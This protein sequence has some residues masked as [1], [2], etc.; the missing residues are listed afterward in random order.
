MTI[1]GD[2]QNY[3]KNTAPG[4]TRNW[5]G[6]I[7]T[8][9]DNKQATYT[10]PYNNQLSLNANTPLSTLYQN[11][12]IAN[13]WDTHYGTDITQGLAP[14]QRQEFT[15]PT[16]LYPTSTSKQSNYSSGHSHSGINWNSPLSKGLLPS[17][18]STGQ[19][20]QSLTEN[21]GQTLQDQY[22]NLMQRALQPQAFQG[23]LND[24]AS[25]RMLNS[26]VAKDALSSAGKGIARMVADQA[27]NS[28]LAQQQA[29]MQVPQTLAN[30]ISLSQETNQSN[31][32]SS[33]SS[34]R[35]SNP[36]EPY[37]LMSQMLRYQ[38][39]V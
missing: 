15:I 20:L 4:T 25:K 17:L 2:Y 19:N 11:P 18:L 14:P 26:T 27:F 10:D 31:K 35:S 21:M 29:Q 23:T 34:A 36:L 3:F 1:L 5:A 39:S 6:G 24:L 12:N 32:S 38:P 16:D 37:E 22:A 13:A 8:M 30:L 28:Q 9:G 33:S 7:L